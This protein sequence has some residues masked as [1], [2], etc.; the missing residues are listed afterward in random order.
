[1]LTQNLPVWIGWFHYLDFLHYAWA[2]LMLNEFEHKNTVFIDNQT[3]G[4][5]AK[6]NHEM[7]VPPLRSSPDTSLVPLPNANTTCNCSKVMRDS[8]L[9]MHGAANAMF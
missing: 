4:T 1:M 2:S 3:V 8:C 9:C 5:L 7:P 6:L